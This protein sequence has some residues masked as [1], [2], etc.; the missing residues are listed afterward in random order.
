MTPRR[1]V[2][3]C[4]DV[5]QSDIERAHEAGY[6]D[7]ESIKRF[8]ALGTGICQGRMCLAPAAQLLCGLERDA[9]SVIRPT[10]PR[11]PVVPTPLQAFA[12]CQPL[13]ELY[14]REQSRPQR[15]PARPQA[16]VPEEADIV[17]IGGGIL[18]LATAYHLARLGTSNVVV[19]EQSYLNA[20]ASGRNGGGIRAQW[21][22]EE[23]VALMKESVSSCRRF[24][25]DLGVNIWLRQGG[26]LFVARDAATLERMAELTTM[27]NRLGVPT[28]I[29]TAQKIPELVPHLYTAD[30]VGAAFNP[31]DGVV[32]P[33]PFVWA[34]ADAARRLGTRVCTFTPAT[35]IEVTNGRVSRVVTPG[36]AI[37]CGMVLNAAAAWAPEVAALVGVTLP[38]LP[39]RHEILVTE[40]LRPFLEPLVCELDSGLYFSQSLRGE[41]VGGMGDPEQPPGIETRSSLRFVTRM[42]QALIARMP[43]LGRVKVVR[44][45]AGCYD[46]TPDGNPIIGEVQTPRGFYQLHGFVGHGFMMAPVV[47]RLVAEELTQ[48]RS[49]P[50]LTKNR[51]ERFVQPGTLAK[52]RMIIG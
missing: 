41:L 47:G 21:S 25:K 28:R 2:C 19:L 44:Q 9:T 23:N 22:S 27:Q 42:A 32:F 50:F 6:R 13:A 24:A 34:Y 39:V 40:S 18:G 45:W 49:H 46:T 31:E 14:P 37:R 35:A 30:L 15:S 43:R 51:I 5:C 29:L 26:Y 12:S 16:F 36:G 20:G 11:P 3:T 10:T 17:I 48:G 33:W 38:N 1:L 52:E 4:E 8:T 7:L